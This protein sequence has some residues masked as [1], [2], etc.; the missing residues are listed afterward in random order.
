MERLKQEQEQE[1]ALKKLREEQDKLRK[2][3]FGKQLPGEAEV[4]FVA[5]HLLSWRFFFFVFRCSQRATRSLASIHPTILFV[6]HSRR[7]ARR[8]C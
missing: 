2:D 6:C 4:C 1:A 7:R 5:C 8:A 3:L